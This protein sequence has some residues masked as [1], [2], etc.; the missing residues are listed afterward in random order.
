MITEWKCDVALFS[1]T[2]LRPTTTI[3][4]HLSLNSFVFFRRDRPHPTHGGVIVYEQN[5]LTVRRRPDLEH[6]LECITFELKI[7]GRKYFCFVAIGRLTNHRI[8]FAILW[9]F[10]QRRRKNLPLSCSDTLR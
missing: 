9:L 7:T 6:N 4:M 5:Y 1:E 2:W 3:D 8:F 10:P